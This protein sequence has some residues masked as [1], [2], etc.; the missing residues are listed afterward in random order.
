MHY[1]LGTFVLVLSSHGGDG[2]VIGSDGINLKLTDIY[3]LLSPKNFPAMK[4]K[5]KMII[6]QACSGG[7]TFDD[8]IGYCR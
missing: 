1:R 4:G 2:C 6:I 3:N 8:T 7:E 5:P